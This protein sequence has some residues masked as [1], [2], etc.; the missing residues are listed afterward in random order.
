MDSIAS[1]IWLSAPVV[2]VLVLLVACGPQ[3]RPGREPPKVESRS[4]SIPSW[5]LQPPVDAEYTYGVGTDLG[6]DRAT[7]IA[8]A[9]RDIAHQLRIVIRSDGQLDEDDLDVDEDPNGPPRVIIDHLELPGITV[10][11]QAETDHCLYV[12]VALNRSAWSAALR[13]RI[14]ELDRDIEAILSSHDLQP[15]IDPKAHPV[16]SAARLHQRLMPL[17]SA[18]EE[19]LSHLLIAKPGAIAPQAPITLAEMRERLRKVLDRV[20]VDIIAAPDLEAILPQ[21]T[22]T[23]AGIGLRISPGLLNQPTLRLRLTLTSRQQMVDGMERLD[24]SFQ[25]MIE[26]GDGTS[27]GG[28]TITLRSSSLT[29]T[30]ARDRLMQKIMV[31]WAEYIEK[32]FVSYL[33]RL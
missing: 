31:R 29:T 4:N 19:K 28:I 22:A 6:K 25:C 5:V 33:T 17:V 21:L 15:D 11:R 26:T 32:D 20:T 9:R 13:N 30:V 24:G 3:Y 1:R 2:G 18:R 14:S 23:C 27:L 7:A 12:Q 10:T 16:G 8:D